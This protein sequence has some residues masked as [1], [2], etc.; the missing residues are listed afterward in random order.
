MAYRPYRGPLPPL[1]SDIVC[2]KPAKEKSPASS[3]ASDTEE[4]SYD[5]DEARVIIPLLAARACHLPGNNVCQDWMQFIKNNH[6][7]LGIIF[8]HPLHPLRIWQRIV[9]LIGSVAF[10]LTATNIVFL[11]HVYYETSMDEV[12]FRVSLSG[13][14]DEGSD[15]TTADIK[16]LEITY[17]AV[18]LWTLGGGLHSIFDLSLWFLSACACFLPGGCFESQRNLHSIGSYCVISIVAILVAL[19]T[20]LVVL[21]VTYESRLREKIED[22]TED[23]DWQEVHSLQSYN[24]VLG[25]LI[26]L[27]LVYCVHYPFVA[28]V[29]FS[30]ILS[31]GCLPFLGGRPAEIQQELRNINKA[32]SRLAS[33]ACAPSNSVAPTPSNS[34]SNNA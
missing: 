6:P 24:F 31:F 10:G 23:V 4:D 1:A 13:G 5:S 25:Y 17:G 29:F 8:H 34:G 26:E 14:V 15:V 9:N 3:P 32:N 21:R 16:Q 33:L 27:V 11:M 22:N 20:S 2:D 18:T 7:V 19:T 28:S 30:G 12:F